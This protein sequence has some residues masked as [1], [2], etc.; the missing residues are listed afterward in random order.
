MPR[1]ISPYLVVFAGVVGLAAGADSQV[2][3]TLAALPDGGLPTLPD[4][5]ELDQDLLLNVAE[6][7]EQCAA[8]CASYFCGVV[9]PL[10]PPPMD[11]YSQGPL[12]SLDFPALFDGEQ[13]IHVSKQPLFTADECDEAIRLAELEGL[14]LPTSKSGKYQIGKAWIEDMPSVLAWFNRALEHKL[15]PIMSA[16]FPKLLPP[17]ASLRAHKV[18]VLKYNT[19]HPQ[20]DIHVDEALL[21]FT[22]ALSPEGAFEGGGT[23]FEYID[24]VVE[25]AQGHATFRPGSVRH[26]G[27]TVT[28]GLRYVVGGFIAVNERVE[29]VRRRPTHRALPLPCIF[30]RCTADSVRRVCG[31]QVRRLN[32]RGNKILLQSSPTEPELGRAE[33]LFR[34]AQSINPTCTLCHQNLG[35]T[36]LRLDRPVEAEAA[37]RSQL[38][39]LPRDSDAFFALGNALTVQQRTTEAQASYNSALEISPRDYESLLGLADTHAKLNDYAAEADAYRRALAIRPEADVRVLLNPHPRARTHTHTHVPSPSSTGARAPQPGRGA[40]RH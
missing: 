16:L 4:D 31:I 36:L 24:R 35:D 11:V 34:W 19:S 21:A 32:E 39:L 10:D 3:S 9:P 7:E 13:T 25:M 30:P 1:L 27:S 5:P 22:I 6:H 20:T 26:S 15:F 23:Y 33:K 40:L 17:G 28:A 2:R 12:P 38:V 14:G 37:L 29:H 18:A 8:A